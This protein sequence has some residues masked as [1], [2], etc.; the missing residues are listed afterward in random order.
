M[1]PETVIYNTYSEKSDIWALGI[2]LY[3]ML[4]GSHYS[5]QIRKDHSHSKHRMIKI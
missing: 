4:C 1:A 3:E 5:I 2:V